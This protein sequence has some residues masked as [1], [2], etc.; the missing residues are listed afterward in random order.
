MIERIDLPGRYTILGTLGAGVSGRVLRAH[1]SILDQEVALKL[2]LPSDEFTDETFKAEFRILTDLD[3]RNL[4]KV[5]DFGFVQNNT[6]YYSMDYVAGQ[7]IRDF[8]TDQ[9]THVHLYNILSSIFSAMEYLHEREII[10]ADIKPE[11]IMISEMDNGDPA[12]LLLD[13]GMAMMKNDIVTKISG[14]PRY[15]APEILENHSYSIKSDLFALGVTLAECLTGMDIPMAI[16]VDDDLRRKIANS[17]ISRLR[18]SE[19]PAPS[20][21][22]SMIIS[23]IHPDPGMR[24]DNAGICIQSI[25]DIFTSSSRTPMLT[26]NIFIGR[27]V[28]M[29]FLEKFITPNRDD[30]NSILI[31][32]S[33]GVG[34]R[35]LI[36]RI[37]TFAQTQ[38][39]ITIN[40]ARTRAMAESMELFIHLLGNNLSEDEKDKLVSSHEQIVQSI[41]LE[42]GPGSTSTIDQSVIIFD[43]IVQFLHDLSKKQKVLICIPD[44]SYFDTYFIRFVSHLVYETDL[45]GSSVLILLS[46]STDFPV[47]ELKKESLDR[48]MALSCLARHTLA[49]LMKDQTKKFYEKMLGNDLFTERE[50]GIIFNATKG[51]PLYV[52][53]LLRHMIASDIIYHNNESWLID[54]NK[55]MSDKVSLSFTDISSLDIDRF[56][57]HE[58]EILLYLACFNN[59]VSGEILAIVSDLSTDK[60]T[61]SIDS[62]I[63]D[64]ILIYTDEA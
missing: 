43:N 19:I 3:H 39:L 2:L 57:F 5:H 30:S 51:I 40:I 63:Y 6:P 25:Q 32:G 17:I 23:L 27:D 62:L 9:E 7:N 10:H 53:K 31:D 56:N 14:T 26:T 60:I 8:F 37:S 28:D 44:I 38:N 24:P 58:K 1:D 45:L 48:L 15:I 54:H 46:H 47:P 36:D 21:L 20:S 35:T 64:N 49:P 42:D 41:S 11:N 55:F 29:A 61:T 12:L 16:N 22:A 33:T 13:F 50:F 59:P 4:I 34:K 18:E 52:D